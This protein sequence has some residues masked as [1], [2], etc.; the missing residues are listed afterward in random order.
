LKFD[1]IMR[2]L[3]LFFSLFLFCSYSGL[4]AAGIT[5]T[6]EPDQ[7]YRETESIEVR[8]Q[9]PVEAGIRYGLQSGDYPFESTVRGIQQVT[10]VPKDEGMSPGVYY[11][12][13]SASGIQSREF[14]LYIE[15]GTA[16]KMLQPENNSTLST[17]APRFRWDPVSG[18]PFYHIILSDRPVKLYE[19]DNGD[20]Q[21]DGGNII[22]QAITSDHSAVY[23]EPDPSGFFKPLTLQHPPLIENTE[24]NWVV[25]NNY[26]N[27]PGFSSIVQAGVSSF[28]ADLGCELSAPDNL[29]PRDAVRLT[30][31]TL[32]FRWDAVADA[33]AYQL[34]LSETRE[35][36]GSE[37]SYLIW[38]PITKETIIQVNA[39]Q[40][41]RAGRYFW[42]VIALDQAGRGVGSEL[43]AFEYNVPQATLHI[44]TYKSDLSILPRAEIEIIPQDGSSEVSKL[45]TTDSGRLDNPVHPGTY[46]IWARKAGYADTSMTVTV[47][48]AEERRVNLVCRQLVQSVTGRVIDQ[49]GI[50]VT[51]AE[52]TLSRYPSEETHST[53]TDPSGVFSLRVP[54]GEWHLR[55]DKE[56]YQQS[57]PLTIDLSPGEQLQLEDI[58]LLQQKAILRGTVTS[59]AGR[60]LAN[61]VVKAV[62]GETVRSTLTGQTGRFELELRADTWWVSA[63]KTG[64]SS[65]SPRR[66]ELGVGERL[67][68]DPDIS[69]TPDAALVSGFVRSSTSLLAQAVIRAVPL[70]GRAQRTLS[71]AVGSFEQS[72]TEGLY[73][74]EV[75]RPGYRADQYPMIQLDSGETVSDMTLTM[76]QVSAVVEGRVVRS[77]GEPVHGA[78]IT[79]AGAQDTSHIDGSYRLA[80]PAGE[81]AIRAMAYGMVQ[82]DSQRVSIEPNEVMTAVMLELTQ[83][84]GVIEGM[85]WA[86]GEGVA[87]ASITATDGDQSVSTRSDDGGGY[88][89]SVLPGVWRIDVEKPGLA[90]TTLDGIAVSADQV[91]GG[92]DVQ[93]TVLQ[94]A[95]QGQVVDRHNQ[96]LNN[97][98]LMIVGENRMARTHRDGRFSFGLEPGS[99]R[100]RAQKEGYVVKEK[101]MTLNE[102]QHRVV[103]FT[104][105]PKAVF[106]GTI[107]DDKGL[108]LKGVTVTAL[109]ADTVSTL[110]DFAGEYRLFS[111]SGVILLQ[112]DAMGYQ[113]WEKQYRISLG[114]SVT[115]DFILTRAPSEIA[116]LSGRVRNSTDDPLR[117][118]RLYL[119]AR[120]DHV[121]LTDLSGRYK[122]QALQT[123]LSVS[124]R[125]LHPSRFFV[126]PQRLYDPLDASHSGQNFLAGYYGD[127]SANEQVSAFDGS[128][129]LRKSAEQDVSPHFTR[130][131]RDTMAADVSG[132]HQISPFD[133]S[134]IFRYSAGLLD[135]FPVQDKRLARPAE[136]ATQTTQLALK[137]RPVG[138]GMVRIDISVDEVNNLYS[139]LFDIQLSASDASLVEC[140]KTPLTQDARIETNQQENRIRVAMASTYPIR[141]SG[142]L[143][144]LLVQDPSLMN[145]RLSYASLNEGGI[146]VS[147]AAMNSE[148]TV[149]RFALLD[150]Y[151]NPFNATTEIGYELPTVGNRHYDVEITIFDLLG[152]V[153][154]RIP[155]GMQS[156][157]RYRVVW[158]GRNDR[159]EAVPSGLYFYRLNAGTVEMRK[160]CILLR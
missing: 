133:A 83:R 93:L 154:R 89:L 33:A 80:V 67:E 44:R 145:V 63:E 158:A 50:P 117:G 13:V 52:V 151:P 123:G 100:I 122:S 129:I 140:Q 88:W 102:N 76:T 152:R 81:H 55:V 8:W 137:S 4:F 155:V 73:T 119:S 46:R 95:V 71:N 28:T 85:I 77:S 159:G 32:T 60:P 84:A 136:A 124:V 113:S 127:V 10:L 26:H 82:T 142:V 138:P 74:F 109:G 146:P 97:A 120:D 153:V 2:P 69:L 104:L 125:P 23:G 21:L 18:V 40:L 11:C 98:R 128:L 130:L 57:D 78:I 143:F 43:H 62:S 108:E 126:P 61:C 37:S 5:L 12:I 156:G 25:L 112:A 87:N 92:V 110:T 160:K 27:H 70:M 139:G 131:P 111:R 6:S 9:E 16:A 141:G 54:R 34:L 19:D 38:A 99:Y 115:A 75:S 132:N 49:N 24:Y 105:D 42:R 121:L 72:L 118:V 94:S 14:V 58:R 30:D 135:R 7:L 31:E 1:T 107:R 68:L 134:L 17:G 64:Y 35:Q 144:Y 106:F 101:D 116:V 39:R 103:N 22:W 90:P 53:V 148:P 51:A 147:F 48:A 20:L 56:G 66:I 150:N 91:I 79:C 29:L 157:G 36:A 45:L 3:I 59:A 114:D 149:T 96:A 15:S 86:E 65:P 47:T 41:L